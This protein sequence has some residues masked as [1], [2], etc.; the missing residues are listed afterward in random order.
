MACCAACMRR[1]RRV[2]CVCARTLCRMQ[3]RRRELDTESTTL[4]ATRNGCGRPTCAHP[5]SNGLVA[6][7][8]RRIIAPRNCWRARLHSGIIVN[9]RPFVAHTRRSR[10]CDDSHTFAHNRRSRMCDNS[11][12]FRTQSGP[13]SSP[14]SRHGAATGFESAFTFATRDASIRGAY[15]SYRARTKFRS[16]PV[17]TG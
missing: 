16:Y 8:N 17:T 9:V 7:R 11:H 2:L 12:T 15:A 4:A 5:L 3:C 13:E 1:S 14:W 6:H 10:M